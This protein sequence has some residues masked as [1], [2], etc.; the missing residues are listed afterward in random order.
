M[1]N[2]EKVYDR[3]WRTMGQRYGS[4]WLDTYGS[5]PTQAWQDTLQSFTPLDIHAAIGLLDGRQQTRDFPP[6]EPEFRSLL[7]Q[8]QRRGVK[9]ADDPAELRRG[10]WRSC[11]IHQVARGLGYDFVVTFEPVLVA[12]PRVRRPAQR[13]GRART[14]HRAAHERH[15]GRLRASLPRDRRRV[16]AAQSRVACRMKPGEFHEKRSELAKITAA[17]RERNLERPRLAKYRCG[18]CGVEI[19]GRLVLC[20]GCSRRAK[21]EKRRLATCSG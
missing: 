6:T 15:G 20:G 12:R 18:S 2:T 16:R 21:L 3:F 8:A 11:I 7:K 1:S 9:I 19:G 17:Q 14:H 10:Y 13:L 5:T 4:R